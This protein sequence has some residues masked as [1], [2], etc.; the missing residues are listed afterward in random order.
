MRSVH[1]GMNVLTLPKIPRSVKRGT[2]V[3]KVCA[4]LVHQ[5]TGVKTP[6]QHLFLVGWATLHLQ[7][8]L[9]VSHVQVVH[10][11]HW[12]SWKYLYLAQRGRTRMKLAVH[13]VEFVLQGFLALTQYHCLSIA[14]KVTT[15]WKVMWYV[16]H[17][18]LATTVQILPCF[19][20]LVWWDLTLLELL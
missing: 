20:K 12:I 4:L 5:D 1:L 11:V 7:K 13:H 8:V 14:V 9:I 16:Y 17:A 19:H 2:M 10:F 3:R 6:L 18:L 15:H